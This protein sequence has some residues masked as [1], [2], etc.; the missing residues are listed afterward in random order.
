[1][2]ADAFTSMTPTA[3]RLCSLP[4]TTE[5]FPSIW[6]GVTIGALIVPIVTSI[7]LAMTWP[8]STRCVA[9]T[10]W[11]S[12]GLPLTFCTRPERSSASLSLSLGTGLNLKTLTSTNLASEMVLADSAH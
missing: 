10:A 3:N 1:L 2:P 4:F 6:P 7:D 8:P 12:S 11:T 9:H 5:A